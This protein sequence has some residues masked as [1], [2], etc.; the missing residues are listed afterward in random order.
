MPHFIDAQKMQEQHPATFKAPS[1]NELKNIVVDNCVKVA[2]ER[3]RFW[4]TV[5]AIEND[6]ITGTIENNLVHSDRHDFHY[7][8]E[9]KVNMNNVYN[10][11]YL[12]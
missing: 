4:I 3:E 11:V 12:P 5:T 7:G 9:I 2:T 1:L 8:D 6:I 10:I